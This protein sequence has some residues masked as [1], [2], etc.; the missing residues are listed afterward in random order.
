MYLCQ[1]YDEDFH[2]IFVVDSERAFELA[3]EMYCSYWDGNSCMVGEYNFGFNVDVDDVK[4]VCEEWKEEFNRLS[5]KDVIDV[6]INLDK[7][8]V[9]VFEKDVE[10]AV[11]QSAMENEEYV[12]VTLFCPPQTEGDV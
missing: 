11:E 4:E 2:A 9:P 5:T 1:T 6:L 10:K 8:I 7:V 3:K 12:I